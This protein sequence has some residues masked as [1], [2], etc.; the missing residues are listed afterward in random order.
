MTHKEYFAKI[1]KE[2][3]AKGVTENYAPAKFLMLYYEDLY[4]GMEDDVFNP[5]ISI[6]LQERGAYLTEVLDWFY[7]NKFDFDAEL[8]RLL[9][10]L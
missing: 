3:I 2:F 9:K 7:E 4:E 5:V 1:K 6:D 8:Q 10:R